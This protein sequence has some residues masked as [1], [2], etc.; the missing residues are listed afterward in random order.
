M[1]HTATA[2]PKRKKHECATASSQSVPPPLPA[3]ILGPRRVLPDFNNLE[4][5]LDLLRTSK[6]I[7]V[8]TGAGIR[9]DCVRRFS[10]LYHVLG[11]KGGKQRGGSGKGLAEVSDGPTF[12]RVGKRTEIM[13]T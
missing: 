9:Q 7:V 8:L 5:L 6:R 13:G 3:A 1:R 12:G 2:M 4:K 11:R 10:S